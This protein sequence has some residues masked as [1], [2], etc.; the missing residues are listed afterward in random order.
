IA[1]VTASIGLIGHLLYFFTRWAGSGHVPV[2]NMYEFMTFL[3]MAIM[4]AFLVLYFIYK[5]SLL[6][7]FALPLAI[8]IM[9][10]AAVFPQQVQPLIPSL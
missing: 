3:S 6:G 7:L 10:Y 4:I 1:F 8:L 9:A 5:K 2:S